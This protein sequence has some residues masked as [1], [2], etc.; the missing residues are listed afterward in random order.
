M[1]RRV[2]LWGLWAALC[3]VML[4]S[5]AGVMTQQPD[6]DKLQTAATAYW[7]ARTTRDWEK[8][9]PYELHKSK[10]TFETYRSRMEA[11]FVKMPMNL[12][13]VED[14]VLNPDGESGKVKVVVR[15]EFG[16]PA[17][18][19]YKVPVSDPWVFVKGEW[20]HDTGMKMEK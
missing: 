17:R 18:G 15:V 20:L 1:V 19:S 9:Y 5:C 3:A 10:E 13:G 8:A 12:V 16:F 6:A 14:A 7:Q 4:C 11:S 2:L